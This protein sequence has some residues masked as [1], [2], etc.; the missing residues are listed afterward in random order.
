MKNYVA[1]GNAAI[2]TSIYPCIDL[3]LRQLVI[4]C[5][6]YVVVH[7]EESMQ[8][9]TF[10]RQDTVCGS[11]LNLALCFA[12]IQSLRWYH[13]RTCDLMHVMGDIHRIF[14]F[15]QLLLYISL[16]NSYGRHIVK[17]LDSGCF[18]SGC[19]ILLL[20]FIAVMPV[21]TKQLIILFSYQPHGSTDYYA[22]LAVDNAVHRPIAVLG[23]ESRRTWLLRALW[24]ADGC[25]LGSHF[26]ASR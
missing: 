1:A 9:I 12:N 4:S 23:H 21:S 17:P 19:H 24:Y 7:P 6:L 13:G 22:A 16:P 14:G 20:W 5:L 2:W 10:M 15:G 26:R 3:P 18:R 8:K 25:H 11:A